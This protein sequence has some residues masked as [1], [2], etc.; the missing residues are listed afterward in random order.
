[1][2]LMLASLQHVMA[3]STDAARASSTMEAQLKLATSA[4]ISQFSEVLE[5]L[6]SPTHEFQTAQG[7][8]T[9]VL[10]PEI[11]NNVNNSIKQIGEVRFFVQRAYTRIK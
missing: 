10:H 11:T 2:Q 4:L 8:L 1:M 3:S 6:Q 9:R 5:A 7:F